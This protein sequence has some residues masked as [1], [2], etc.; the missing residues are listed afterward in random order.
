MTLSA[1]STD[2]AGTD[3]AC[4]SVAEA[5]SSALLFVTVVSR[6]F[7]F[8]LFGAAGD[9][10]PSKIGQSGCNSLEAGRYAIMDRYFELQRLI[11]KFNFCIR[12]EKQQSKPKRSV[13]DKNRH[14]GNHAVRFSPLL[15]YSSSVIYHP[16]Y[17]RLVVANT[18]EH[19][20]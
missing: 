1:A 9:G 17:Q 19:I 16:S 10:Q 2:V 15:M 5:V 18:V 11:L 3:S 7:F 20:V 14:V 13:P 8:G 12:N 6:L 4:S